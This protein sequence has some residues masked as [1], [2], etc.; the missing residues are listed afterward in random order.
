MAIEIERKFLVLGDDWR[1][2]AGSPLLLRQAY[3]SNDAR[4][5]IRT[6]FRD[7]Y[8]NIIG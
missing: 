6:S 1:Q 4:A 8:A 5:S 7:H 3:L 2:T